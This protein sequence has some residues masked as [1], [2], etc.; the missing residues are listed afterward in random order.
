MKREQFLVGFLG[1]SYNTTIQDAPLPDGY[2]LYTLAK[3][4]SLFPC[5]V[6]FC[7]TNGQASIV[8]IAQGP[9]PWRG[10]CREFRV[11][12]KK[13]QER[14]EKLFLSPP[15]L[16]FSPI[17]FLLFLSNLFRR[18]TKSRFCFNFTNNYFSWIS[19]FQKKQNFTTCWSLRGKALMASKVIFAW[20]H[21]RSPTACHCSWPQ[22][23][24]Y[25]SRDL[26]IPA[27]AILPT[28][29]R[30]PCPDIEHRW[31][32]YVALTSDFQVWSCLENI[33]VKHPFAHLTL[34]QT[35]AGC[36]HLS[37]SC[38]WFLSS[39]CICSPWVHEQ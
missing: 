30:V 18:K 35:S 5:R 3:Q 24:E 8:S 4:P 25:Y 15:F 39:A 29:P 2:A 36:G 26:R 1:W 31:E 17:P 13:V 33:K 9:E 27:A 28:L 34:T 19:G 20:W 14:S 38:L 11:C 10:F 22:R 23:A 16:P 6:W 21:M 32:L 7:V 37:L 12:S